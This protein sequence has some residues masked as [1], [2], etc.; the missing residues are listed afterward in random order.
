MGGLAR[1]G[2]VAAK[3]RCIWGMRL[4][5]DEYRRMA[6][7]KSVP[8]LASFLR[9]H[10][11]WGRALEGV[12]LSAVKRHELEERLRGWRLEE[13]LRLYPYTDARDR[14]LLS[15]P[16]LE[17]E[18]AQI[19][20]WLALARAGRAQ[21]YS[22]SPPP[23]AARFSKVNYAALSSALTFEAMI[24]AVSATP[25]APV[26]RRL[27][28]ACDAAGD[29]FPEFTLIETALHGHYFR[30]LTD[31]IGRVKDPGLRR[32]L[33][34]SV[35][36]RADLMNISVILRLKKWYGQLGG[37]IL[38][39]IIPVN[40]N[41]RPAFLKRLYSAGSYSDAAALLRASVYGKHFSREDEPDI[42]MLITRIRFEHSLRGLREGTP[43]VL[44]P[45]SFIELSGIELQNIIHVIECVRYGIPPEEAMAFVV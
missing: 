35:G 45:F 27:K 7:M 12:N 39:Y 26:L 32:R 4:S 33:R 6:A 29:D 11:R 31:I 3:V 14:D 41:L 10:V 40:L 18:L 30:T 24:D 37:Q 9:G 17:T 16:I 22:F 25:Y 44:T 28:Q 2:A 5:P 43:T 42:D 13:A 19:M 1:Y 15:F 36:I 8:E 20:R 21:E 38:N 23:L 34:E